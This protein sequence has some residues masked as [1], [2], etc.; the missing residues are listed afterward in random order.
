MF[1]RCAFPGLVTCGV[2]LV[3]CST[4]INEIPSVNP[5]KVVSVKHLLENRLKLVDT[6]V[7]VAGFLDAHHDGSS[8]RMS[9]DDGKQSVLVPYFGYDPIVIENRKVISIA[10]WTQWTEK[11]VVV[12][13]TFRIAPFSHMGLVSPDVAI[14]DPNAI[15]AVKTGDL[16]RLMTITHGEQVGSA[17]P[18]TRPESRPEGN[19]KPQPEAERRSW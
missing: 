5:N 4:S 10:R 15:L 11:P 1:H 12:F 18:A 2:L 6:D 8:L 3:G 16:D 9:P 14:I 19:D 7:Q 17:Q 13:G